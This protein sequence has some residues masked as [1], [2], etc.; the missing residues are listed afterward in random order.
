MSISPCHL[1]RFS[2]EFQLACACCRVA[3]TADD[4]VEIKRL[5]AQIDVPAFVNLVVARHRI[6]SI[7]HAVLRQLPAQDLP[8]GLLVPLSEAAR[9]NAVKA[10]QAQRTLIMLA[11]WFAQAGIHWLPFK[12]L[13]VALRYY[14][15]FALRHVNDLDVWVPKSRLLQAR[16]LLEARGFRL[17]VAARH[18]DL[19]QRGPRH[20]DYLLRYYFEEQHYSQEFGT[21]ELHWKLTE[22]FDQFN[23]APERLLEQADRIDVGGA[24]MQVMNDVDLLLYLCEHGGRHGWYRLKWLADLPR[25]L[26]SRQWDWQLVL[27]RARSAGSL[28]TLLL[29]LALCRDLYGWAPPLPVDRAMRSKRFLQFDLWSIWQKLVVADDMFDYGVHLP[30]TWRVLETLRAFPLSGSWRTVAQHVW[31]RSL[32]PN[33]LRVLELPDRWFGLYYLLRPFLFASRQWRSWTRSQRQLPR[34]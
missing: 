4:G 29:G 25:I 18:W 24:S 28:Q 10:L 26:A 34:A 9:H 30:L 19:A 31:R 2:P 14:G 3:P 1:S 6:G 21:L 13:T 8:P 7:V 20:L 33:D 5:L 12:G 11:R 16:A 17:D 27:G 23:V 32:S 15:D 22:N